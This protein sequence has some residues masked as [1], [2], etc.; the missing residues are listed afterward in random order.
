MTQ[1]TL[2]KLFNYPRSLFH[3]V[4]AVYMRGFGY[5]DLYLQGH[6]EL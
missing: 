4:L 1:L 5:L 6:T 2:L 3:P